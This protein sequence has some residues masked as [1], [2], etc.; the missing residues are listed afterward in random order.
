MSKTFIPVVLLCFALKVN[1]QS[2]QIDTLIFNNILTRV[3]KTG[4]PGPSPVI[5]FRC[6]STH[7]TTNPPFIIDGIL[8]DN[9]DLNCL[10]PMNIESINIIKGISAI[11]CYGGSA[12][13]GVVLITTKQTNLRTIQVKDNLDGRPIANATVEIFSK[14]KKDIIRLIV[15]STGSVI[16]NKIVYGKEYA[17]RVSSIGYETYKSNINSK[18]PEKIHKVLLERD[19]KKLNEVVMTS[20]VCLRKISCGI[21]IVHILPEKNEIIKDGN[22]DFKVYPNPAKSGERINIKWDKAIAGEYVFSIYNLQ[23]QLISSESSK[24]ESDSFTYLFKL[25]A[26]P[27]G[28]YFLKM[29]NKKLNKLYTEKIIIQ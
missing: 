14:E 27:S 25:T 18:M 8:A 15:D 29:A 5:K 4:T 10:D 12:K 24:N 2:L 1:S 20:T 26:L 17:I 21:R 6:L 13:E 9:D 7:R 11:L 28:T 22:N 23:G 16:T 3:L 19:I